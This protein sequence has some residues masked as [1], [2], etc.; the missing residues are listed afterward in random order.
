MQD[1]VSLQMNI[2]NAKTVLV[3]ICVHEKRIL[4]GE[5]EWC[6]L[7]FSLLSSSNGKKPYFL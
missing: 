7:I 6:V 3:Y 1:I 4:V 5:P 2:C